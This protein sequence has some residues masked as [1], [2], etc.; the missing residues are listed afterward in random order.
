MLYML[1][2]FL[3]FWFGF[4]VWKMFSQV[5]KL[6]NLKFDTRETFDMQQN[7]AFFKMIWIIIT[8]YNPKSI[9]LVRWIEFA[10]NGSSAT[11]QP[12]IAYRQCHI[13]QSGLLILNHNLCISTSYSKKSYRILNFYKNTCPKKHLALKSFKNFKERLDSIF[14]NC[15]ETHPHQAFSKKN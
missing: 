13:F 4:A 8:I 10:W 7:L 2:L 5:T 9:D 1:F 11:S 6:M 3:P 14:Q 15:L 12:F